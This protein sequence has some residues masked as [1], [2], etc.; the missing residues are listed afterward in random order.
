MQFKEKKQQDEWRSNKLHPKVTRVCL[1]LESM[2][3]LYKDKM[4][5]GIT[6]TSIYRE[7]DPKY[8]GKW[9]AVDV[10]DRD[11]DHRF[12]RIA[13]VVLTGLRQLDKRVQHEFE[14]TIRDEDTG[15]VLKGQ[16]LHIEF[17]DNS[18]GV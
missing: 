15:V 7:G 8:H 3:E 13:Q 9:Q 6:I 14:P 11:W 2:A 18:L 1:I 5:D 16:H 10:R 12:F 4:P 17:D